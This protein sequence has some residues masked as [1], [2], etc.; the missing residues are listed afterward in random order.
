MDE[1][2]IL[3]Y[4]IDQIKDKIRAREDDA[5]FEMDKIRAQHSK[6]IQA[7]QTKHEEKL[8]FLEK[9]KIKLIEDKTRTI[10]LEKQKLT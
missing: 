8:N 4:E 1:K 7:L 2:Q 10:D 5:R 6:A 3:E 9:E